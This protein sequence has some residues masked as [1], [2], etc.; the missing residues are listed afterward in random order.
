MSMTN[1]PNNTGNQTTTVIVKHD[2]SNALG[3]ASFI[4]GLISI[5]ILAPIFVPLAVIMG[6][7]AVIKKQLTWGI[8]GLVCAFIGFITSPIL[9]GMFAFLN[10]GALMSSQNHSTPKLTPT[11]V[12][13][14]ITDSANIQQ[15]VASKKPNNPHDQGFPAKILGVWVGSVHQPNSGTYPV[16]MTINAAQENSYVGIIDY[17]SL[18]CGGRLTLSKGSTGN[19]FIFNEK[20]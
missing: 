5:F 19:H 6:I 4:F 14:K 2:T 20:I 11:K 1:D 10:L 9:L 13:K 3:I 16:V 18:G 17:P 8:T 12:E 7:I 15:A